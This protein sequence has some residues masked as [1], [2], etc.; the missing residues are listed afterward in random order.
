MDLPIDQDP[1][2]C[3]ISLA[4]GED[5][6]NWRAPYTPRAGAQ[7]LTLFL[8]EAD[9]IA[10]KWGLDEQVGAVL[11]QALRKQLHAWRAHLDAASKRAG[12]A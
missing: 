11:D 1:R 7:I 4:G 12:G 9:D 3:L 6:S 10:T 5:P 8:M 2:G